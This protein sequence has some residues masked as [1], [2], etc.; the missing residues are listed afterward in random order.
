M[1]PVPDLPLLLL[2]YMPTRYRLILHANN[3]CLNLY[4]Y[5]LLRSSLC[6]FRSLCLANNRLCRKAD[7]DGLAFCHHMHYWWKLEMVG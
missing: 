5:M 7:W 1:L 4:K 3:R 2:S 6:L